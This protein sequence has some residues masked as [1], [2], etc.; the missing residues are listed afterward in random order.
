MKVSGDERD[1]TLKIS[2]VRAAGLTA[3]TKETFSGGREA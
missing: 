2:K 3:R 1:C